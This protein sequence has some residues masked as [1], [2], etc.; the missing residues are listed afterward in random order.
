MVESARG[1]IAELN[2]ERG[3]VQDTSIMQAIVEYT[4]CPYICITVH[5]FFEHFQTN[6]SLEL[7]LAI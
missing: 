1:A 7:I 5:R 6:V 2:R 4:D 3:Y